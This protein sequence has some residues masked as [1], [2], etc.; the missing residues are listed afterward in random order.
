MARRA[1]N[2]GQQ[3]QPG[4][5]EAPQQANQSTQTQRPQVNAQTNAVYRP[6]PTSGTRPGSGSAAVTPTQAG[7][8]TSSFRPVTRPG[9]ISGA[10]TGVTMENAGDKLSEWADRGYTGS[11]ALPA[12]P[13]DLPAD[14]LESKGT[15]EGE[16][17]PEKSN[18]EMI[19]DL[20]RQYLE[21][22]GN[23]DTTEQEALIEQRIKEQLNMDLM[24]Q[25]ASAGASGFEA[26]GSLIGMEGDIRRQAGTDAVEQILGAR[27]DAEQDAFDRATGAAG[28]NLAERKQ[29]YEEWKAQEQLDALNR[30]LDSEGGGGGGDGTQQFSI[31]QDHD[32]D[33]V[34][35]AVDP[36][37]SNPD[38]PLNDLNPLTGGSTG[39]EAEANTD[40]IVTNATEVASPPAGA[41]LAGSRPPWTIYRDAEG[42]YYKVRQ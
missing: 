8:Q 25:R 21:Q 4:L 16:Q 18:E 7:I 27:R 29:A 2:Q 28:M 26:S 11:V 37:Y 32:Q 17:P 34:L 10:P 23:V 35:N 1:I 33:G 13:A 3:Q 22:A 5:R 40:T 19:N 24:N 20:V 15:Y 14:D 31:E 9:G 38:D 41:T 36:D 12:D 6:G 42:N 30:W 39:P